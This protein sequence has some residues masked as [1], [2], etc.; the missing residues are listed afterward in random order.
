MRTLKELLELLLQEYEIFEVEQNAP[1]IFYTFFCNFLDSLHK[2]NI[3]NKEEKVTLYYKL[4]E[5]KL[6]PV[7]DFLEG[8][9]PMVTREEGYEIRKDLL[10]KIIS[11]L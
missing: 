7:R 1:E 2:K 4:R 9:W 3:I 5:Y 11:E 6:S 8:W 10:R